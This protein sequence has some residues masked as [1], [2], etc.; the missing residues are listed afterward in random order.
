[1]QSKKVTAIIYIILF[2]ISIYWGWKANL[3]ISEWLA[4]AGI[5]IF[6][7]VLMFELFNFLSRDYERR[8]K[9]SEDL[10]RE[11]FEHPATNGYVDYKN[12]EIIV[13]YVKWTESSQMFPYAIQH[14]KNKKYKEFCLSLENAREYAKRIIDDYIVKEFQQYREAV[15]QKLAKAQIQIP[16]SDKFV[17]FKTKRYNKKFVKNRLFD[18]ARNGK[19]TEIVISGVDFSSLVWGETTFANGD[20]P[21]L[22]YLKNVIEQIKN[23]KTIIAIITDIESKKLQLDNNIWLERFNRER[24]DIV[25]QVKYGQNVLEGKCERCPKF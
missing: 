20:T 13:H 2:I 23:D 25:G 19:F 18:E 22:E 6:G 16:A 5:W 24:E 7:A 14:L 10:V 17:D 3:I 21:S 11:V 4:L 9:H 8:L 12:D 15:E 1:M